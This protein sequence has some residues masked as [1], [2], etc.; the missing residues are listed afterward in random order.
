MKKKLIA[1]LTLST[2]ALM[3]YAFNVY[4]NKQAEEEL[5]ACIIEI[6]KDNT[7]ENI[8]VET[9]GR[10]KFPILT[11]HSNPFKK[12]KIIKNINKSCDVIEIEDFISDFKHINNHPFINFSIDAFNNIITI[13]GAFNN[14]QEFQQ[15]LKI[16]NDAMPKMQ[17]QHDVKINEQIKSTDIALD[18][19]LLLPS[20]K[21]IRVAEISI[22]EGILRL[23]G[24]IRDP[25]TEERTLQILHQLFDDKYNIINELQQV[26]DQKEPDKIDIEPPSIP[27][28]EIPKLDIKN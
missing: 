7:S 28:I 2:I 22:N 25:I 8:T 14:Q 13:K 20:I 27:K 17:I 26:N 9:K 19:A 23:N 11:G 3:Y 1:V 16:F 15:V 10:G 24:I 5:R 18:M 6:L 4:Q 12:N 21:S